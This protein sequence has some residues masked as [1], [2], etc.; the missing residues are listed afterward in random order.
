MDYGLW[1]MDYGLWI[2][3]YGL[4]IKIRALNKSHITLYISALL[5]PPT[6]LITL[7]KSILLLLPNNLS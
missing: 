2:M 6:L 3:D 7:T 1:I 5:I 4:F